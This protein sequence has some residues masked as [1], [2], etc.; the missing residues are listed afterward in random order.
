MINW[1]QAMI[2][3][4]EALNDGTNV[5]VMNENA[6]KD[7][8]VI[9]TQ[10]DLIAG[11]ISKSYA[12]NKMLPKHVAEAHVSGEIH[13]HDLDYAIHPMFN[14]MLIDIKGMFEG[15]FS[16]GLADIEDPKSITTATALCAQI[17]AQV[18]SH[19]FGGNTI[20]RIDEILAKYV[21]RSYDKH[22]AIGLQWFEGNERKAAVYAEQQTEKETYD[23]F[24]ALEYEINTLHTSNGQTPFTTLNFGL[25]TSWEA[26]LIQKAILQVRRDGLGKNKK[27]AVFPKLV[28]TIRDGVNFKSGDC[29]YDIKQLALKCA[30]ERMYP[31][32]LNYDKIV[33]VTGDF[34]APMG[35]RSYL[36]ANGYPSNDGRNNLGV[37]SLNLPRIALEANGDMEKFWEILDE[38][39][40]VCK[41]ALMY[42]ISRFDNVQAKVA[43]ILYMHGACG[44]RLQP[45]DCVADIFKN[46]RASVSMGYI[47]LHETVM[48]LR[49]TTTHTF[50]S[51]TKATMTHAIVARLREATDSWK[52][53]TGYGFGLYSTPSESLCDRFC[54][55]DRDVFGD[56]KDVT[57]KEYYTNSFHL[58]VF[59]KVTPFEKI[60]FEKDYPTK[61]SGGFI[62]YVE[63]PNMKNNIK[64][65]ETVWDYTY[66][67]LPYF[68]TNTPVD[69]CG[70]CDFAGES[71]A[72]EKGF[73]C[74]CCGNTDSR[75]LSVTRRVCGYLGN[76]GA[77]PYTHGKQKEVIGRV[78]H[79]A[80]LGQLDG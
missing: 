42:R 33:E 29:N 69:H 13:F 61:A 40:E 79:I 9:S 26:R 53:E 28:F 20:Q 70:L 59:K 19:I 1:T 74:P 55:M 23:A 68:G 58:D 11:I 4:I 64:G 5:A 47:G 78:K 27:T 63:F 30:S 52:K 67:K 48:A 76:P 6:N 43:P 54:R 45:N 41:D 3:E 8:A 34:K 62:S 44:V 22:L 31:D 51:A 10:R 37:V 39:L 2:E 15:G 75:S 7:A 46:G 18:A 12:L 80:K 14:C 35:C 32:V 17:I 73:E 71:K 25:G 49:K 24:Q 66:D 21:R 57:D 50:D 36:S 38:R 77:R 60:D 56:V 65:L 72:T 16:M